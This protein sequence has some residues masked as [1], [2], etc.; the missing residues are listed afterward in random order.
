MGTANNP[1]TRKRRRAAG[2]TMV[3]LMITLA[4]IA[5]LMAVSTPALRE[6]NIRANV[7]STTNDIVIALNLARSEA[8]KRGRLVSVVA[9]GADWS[10]GWTVQ[11]DDGT[12]L[13]SRNAVADNYRVLGAPT[14]AGAQTDRVIFTG[15]GALSVATAWDFSICRPSFS[16]DSTRSRRVIVTAT[17]TVRSRRDTTG[18]PA[19]VCT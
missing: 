16:P 5:I 10:N 7:T 17:G 11:S 6:L 2:F 4:V 18:S 12:V 3:E 13:S 9:N 14:G 8:V 1:P 19:G 15:T